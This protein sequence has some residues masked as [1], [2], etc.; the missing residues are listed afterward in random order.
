[1]SWLSFFR[2]KP[3][4]SDLIDRYKDFRK[5]SIQLN[6][7]LAKQVPKPA[8]PECG[9][10]LGIAKAGALIINNDD[11]IAILYDY[12]LYHYR[13]ADKTVIERHIESSPP[14]PDTPESILLQAMQNARYS[15]FRV[16]EIIPHQ[17]AVL[18]DLVRDE[19]LELVDIGLSSTGTP[20]LILA[21]RILPLPDFNMSSGT[22]IPLPQAA[23]EQ[24]IA[25]MVQKFL[26]NSLPGSGPLFSPSH[27]ASFVAQIIRAALQAGGEENTF[28]TDMEH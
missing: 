1:M 5:V 28:Y 17:G 10:R 22:L 4:N 23:Y 26:R 2:K 7:T 20:G 25:P 14:A 3:K 21:G 8:V 27:E 13:R 16:V 24:T 9:K 12:C 15:V 6:M 18:H 11:E 19:S